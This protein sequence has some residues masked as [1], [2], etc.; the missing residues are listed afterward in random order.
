MNDTQ[1]LAMTISDQILE[2]VDSAG[3]MPRSDLQ[4][5]AEAIAMNIVN[6]A[7]ADDPDTI[8]VSWHVDDV[9]EIAPDLNL[10]QQRHVLAIVK[11]KHDAT[12]GINWDVLGVIADLV[13]ETEA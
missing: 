9:H 8:T 13:R 2:L 1:R 4:G 3:D 6:Q 7:T 5:A 12:I 10:E 11:S